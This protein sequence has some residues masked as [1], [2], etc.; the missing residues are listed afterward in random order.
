MLTER[1]CFIHMPRCGGS[2]FKLLLKLHFPI[3]GNTSHRTATELSWIRV[4][5]I[6]L[7]RD[8]WSWYGSVK[9]ATWVANIVEETYAETFKRYCCQVDGTLGVQHVF[10]WGTEQPWEVAVQQI[11]GMFRCDVPR[12]YGLY[13]HVRATRSAPRVQLDPKDLEVWGQYGY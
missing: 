12:P 1:F 7:L 2:A 4:P 9:K 5:K 3:I 6:A 11:F 8:P 10:S 13:R